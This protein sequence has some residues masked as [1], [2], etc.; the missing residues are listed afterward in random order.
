MQDG[1]EGIVFNIQRFAIQDGPG[2]RSTVF[3]K[4]C[5][6]RCHWCSNPESMKTQPEI[7]IRDIKCIKCGRCVEACPQH[8]ITIEGD[9]RRIHWGKCDYCM[10]CVAVCSAR[11]IERMGE[12]MT[13]D[14]VMD[15]VGRDAGFYKN[16]GGGMTLSGG[17]PLQQWQ[18]ALQL[19]KRAKGRGFHTAVDTTGYA[20]WEV[21][22]QIM[23]YT[24]IMLWD[25]K[26]LDSAK[27]QESTGAPNTL[28]LENLQKAVSR[29]K[30]KIWI[31]RPVVPDFND[32]DE[33]MEVFAKFAESLGPAVEKVSLLAYHKFGS[34]KYPAT[35]RVYTYQGA[36]LIEDERM[37]ELKKLVESHNL[38]VDIG[39]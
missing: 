6:L 27:H 37:E 1:S 32:S 39:R 19:L 20:D 30:A 8:A 15:T 28:I 31:R 14:A 23:N 18:F 22:D 29:P 13:V 36:E 33:T 5:P 17:E 25:V 11:S 34:T 24:D 26:H 16:S 9:I 7:I 21:I 2:I 12:S 10:A 4:G 3:L 35:G 38:K